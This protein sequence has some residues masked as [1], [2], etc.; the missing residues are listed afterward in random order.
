MRTLV[1]LVILT[2]SGSVFAV[3]TQLLFEN[4]DFEKG[5]LLNWE[6]EG[7]AFEI[8]PVKGDNTAVRGARSNKLQGEYWIGTFEGY[9]DKH[10]KLG[11]IRGDSYVG[12]LTSAEFKVEKPYINFLCGGGSS[13][14]TAVFIKVEGENYFL[15][16]GKNA[17]A[18][19]QVSVDVSEFLG[20]HA[21]I[22]IVDNASGGWGHVTADNFTSS[23]KPMVE[24]VKPLI[25]PEDLN[26]DY[27]VDKKYIILP[28]DN[29]EKISNIRVKLGDKQ[30]RFVSASLATRAAKTD[31]WAFFDVSEYKGKKRNVSVSHS[32]EEA[33]GLI[34]LSDTVPDSGETFTE[35]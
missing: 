18:M 12:K 8:Q 21:R 16:S 19:R 4:S 32:N 25:V 28:I 34:K 22:A 30:V 6:A 1:L 10:G 27:K 23:D 20:K 26:A 17:V 31:W 9:N 29:D 14:D 5:S 13:A 15:S 35:R 3:E 11:D 2:V 33:F 7:A 24:A